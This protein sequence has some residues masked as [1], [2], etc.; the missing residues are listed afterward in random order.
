MPAE[1]FEVALEQ[2]PTYAMPRYYRAVAKL[3]LGEVSEA[4]AKLEELA[5][6]ETTPR[7]KCKAG[8]PSSHKTAVGAPP[9][10]I[11]AKTW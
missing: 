2:D 3:Q 5:T 1:H 9:S 4:T 10:T 7:P 6:R 11:A 8:S